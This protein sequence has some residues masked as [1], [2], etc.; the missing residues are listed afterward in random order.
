M[1]VLIDQVENNLN[2]TY[3]KND[4]VTAPDSRRLFHG[5]GGCFPGFEAITI[6]LHHPWLL[7]TLFKPWDHPQASSLLSALTQLLESWSLEAVLVQR[8]YLDNAPC[9]VVTGVLPE[10]LFAYRAGQRFELQLLGHQNSGFFLDMEPGRQ[11]LEERV[12]GRSLLNLFAYTCANSVVAQTAGATRVVNV[13]MSS[14]A[15]SRGRGNHH[16][17]QL[18]TDC[19]QFMKLDILKSWGRIRR[20][21]P[22]DVAVID[23]PSFQPGSFV[24][25]RDYQKIIRRLPEFLAPRGDVLLCLNSPELAENFLPQL[26][27]EHCPQGHWVARLAGSKD[28]PDRDK[29][30]Q[31]KLFHYR[32]D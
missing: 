32:F 28:F 18:Q 11:W 17:N 7:V 25:S 15:L 23:P 12:E 22:F 20:A 24:A 6:D 1:N 4:G 30:R 29:D 5:R 19:I 13:D 16:L 3:T 21:G 2:L 26:M 14:A 31:L 27:E 8:R 9:E 10:R